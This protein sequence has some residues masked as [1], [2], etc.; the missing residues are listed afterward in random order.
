MAACCL[1]LTILLLRSQ[2]DHR[3]WAKD[4]LQKPLSRLHDQLSSP[5]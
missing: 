1:R 5:I 4:R 3:V 2:S